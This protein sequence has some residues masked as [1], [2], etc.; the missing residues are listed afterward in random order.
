VSDAP[1]PKRFPDGIDP[2]QTSEDP[3]YAYSIENP[4]KVGGPQG[5]RGPQSQRLYLEHLRDPKFRPLTYLRVGSFGQT[6]DGHIVDGYELVSQEGVKYL[7]YMD[8]YH[9]EIHPL[10][11]K[12]PKGLYLWK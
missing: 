4:V 12:A 7:I 2:R 3:T 6:G 8:M 9:P 1:R 10:D 11:V 5:Y